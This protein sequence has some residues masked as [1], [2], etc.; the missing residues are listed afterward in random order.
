MPAA[1]KKVLARISDMVEML[2]DDDMDIRS[3]AANQLKNFVIK[4]R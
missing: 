1:V 3:F 4:E 2:N